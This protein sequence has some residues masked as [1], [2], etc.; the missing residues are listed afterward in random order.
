MKKFIVL[1]LALLSFSLSNAQK[2]KVQ[3]AW[4]YLK[5]EDLEKAKQA[6]DEA[7]T[8]EASMGMAKTWYYRGQIYQAMFKNAK[9][10][11]VFTPTS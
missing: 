3:T 6:I 8:N 7:S 11:F 4:N 5:S 1:A 2:S 10:G 9:Y